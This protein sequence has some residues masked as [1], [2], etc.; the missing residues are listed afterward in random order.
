MRFT[1][2]AFTAILHVICE[3]TVVTDPV[4][5]PE[6]PATTDRDAAASKET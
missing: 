2:L 5:E 4:A 1:L 6:K 3:E